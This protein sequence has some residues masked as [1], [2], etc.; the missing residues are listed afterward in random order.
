MTELA[1]LTLV[2]IAALMLVCLCSAYLVF[3]EDYEDGI[4]GRI[5]LVLKML[6]GGMFVA[7]TIHW[8]QEIDPAIAIFAI[9]AAWFMVRHVYRFL[10]A[11]HNPE[12]RWKA[13]GKNTQTGIQ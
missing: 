10:N 11:I 8:R 12:Y 7:R 1:T 6:G 9:G 13:T 5:A 3:H 2:T 4:G